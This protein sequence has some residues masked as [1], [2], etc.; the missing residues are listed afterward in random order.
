[1]II[2]I[3]IIIS[4]IIIIATITKRFYFTLSSNLLLN[5]SITSIYL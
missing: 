3:T 1:M 2:T 4:F 5:L